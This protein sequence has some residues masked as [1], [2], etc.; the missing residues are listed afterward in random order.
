[1]GKA[2][3]S[4]KGDTDGLTNIPVGDLVTRTPGVG[5]S[6]ARGVGANVGEILGAT[7]GFIGSMVDATVGSKLTLGGSLELTRALSVGR[8]E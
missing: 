8:T 2:D 7:D 3:A 5:G 6:V 4:G 1:V